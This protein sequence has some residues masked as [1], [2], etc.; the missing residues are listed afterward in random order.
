MPLSHTKD[1]AEL[2]RGTDLQPLHQHS[3]ARWAKF[4]ARRVRT[5]KATLA[6]LDNKCLLSTSNGGKLH[7]PIS[8]K[9]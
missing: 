7:S 3:P 4:A 5:L 6:A 1:N 2:I 8:D 9:V